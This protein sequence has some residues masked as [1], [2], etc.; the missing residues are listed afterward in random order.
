MNTSTE[1]H[2]CAHRATVPRAQLK[3]LNRREKWADKHDA[4]NNELNAAEDALSRLEQRLDQ[5]DPMGWIRKQAEEQQR[6]G[7]AS[8][9]GSLSPLATAAC[10]QKA[11]R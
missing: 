8:P 3:W 5:M 1:Q 9:V 2:S 10:Y 7:S 6:R 4:V 11:A